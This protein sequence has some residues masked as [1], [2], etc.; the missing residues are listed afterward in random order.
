RAKAMEDLAAAHL[1]GARSQAEA[2]DVLDK[3]VEDIHRIFRDDPAFLGIWF[4]TFVDKELQRLNVLFNARVSDIFYEH[5]KPLLSAG[6]RITLKAGGSMRV[7]MWGAAL[8]FAVSDQPGLGSRVVAETKRAIRVM[9][10][11]EPKV[12]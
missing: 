6:S 10:F 3:V 12:K 5:L 4:G 8:L 1:A 7:H 9:F 11:V 2:L